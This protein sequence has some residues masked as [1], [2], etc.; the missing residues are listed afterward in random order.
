MGR[1]GR[2]RAVSC[3]FAVFF[4]G[5]LILMIFMILA[6][7]LHAYSQTY[8]CWGDQ[9]DALAMHIGARWI[10]RGYVH[11]GDVWA[12]R[13]RETATGIA[14]IGFEGGFA[15]VRAR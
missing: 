12:G 14:H 4:F 13:W 15:L 2:G 7:F 3:A 10:L 11:A 1:F 6:S 8:S 5:H 9:L